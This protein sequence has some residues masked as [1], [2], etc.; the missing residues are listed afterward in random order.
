ME[1]MYVCMSIS[2]KLPGKRGLSSGLSTT[3]HSYSVGL[4]WNETV[5]ETI[6]EAGMMELM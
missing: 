2:D 4:R 1:G 3:P 5:H 6:S